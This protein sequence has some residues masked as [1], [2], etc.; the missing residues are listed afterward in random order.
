[1]RVDLI[2]KPKIKPEKMASFAGRVCYKNKLPKMGEKLD[3]K[4]QLFSSGHHTTLEHSFF[5]FLIEG[6]AISDVT[7]G[8]HL[9]NTFYNSDQRS[10]R[11]SDMFDKP[12][13]D[14][15][16]K[17][18]RQ[19]WPK[20]NDSVIQEILEFVS[21]G[22]SIYQA[23]KVGA[24]E[25]AKKLILKERPNIA[26]K[27]LKRNAPKIAQEQLRNFI[28]TIFPTALVYTIDLVTLASLYKSAWSP[29]MKQAT[30]LMANKVLE[31]Y[32]E[33]A[34]MF[35]RE[36]NMSWSPE[37]REMKGLLFEPEVNNV[38]ILNP[39][40]II[41]AKANEKHPVDLMHFHPRFMDNLTTLLRYDVELSVVTY[42]QDQRHRTIHRSTPSFS[43]NFYLPPIAHKLGLEKEAR[44]ILEKWY[45]L[46]Q[47]L[48]KSLATAIAP[49]GL[50]LNYKKV[51]EINAI[52]HEA[53]KRLCWCA[54]QEIY[55]VWQKI[56]W[57]LNKQGQEDM[58]K[59]LEPPCYCDKCLEGSRYCGRDL[60]VKN[61]PE[62]FFRPREI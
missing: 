7:F 39:Q 50:M 26:E 22:V 60:R 16:E 2:Q 49:Y 21:L 48:P 44:L 24:D 42:G 20:L 46:S 52:T 12:N 36:K 14:Y 61:D 47:K 27:N 57:K 29:G 13:Y 54:Q 6:I 38:E 32:P 55:Q 33:L 9:T 10:G 45:E 43:G 15:I 19:L 37:I 53:E 25:L 5:T 8:L 23:N 31:E 41:F 3:V 30:Q 40:K 1:M 62:K 11:Y 58:L 59:I 28:S 17:Y 34:Y 56:Y 35:K 51:G 18:I 4:N